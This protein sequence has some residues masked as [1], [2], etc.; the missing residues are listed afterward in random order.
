[1]M[2]ERIRYTIGFAFVVGAVL[3]VMLAYEVVP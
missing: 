3:Y 2:F 1:M